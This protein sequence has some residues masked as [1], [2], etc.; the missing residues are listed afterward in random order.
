MAYHGLSFLTSRGRRNLKN[1]ENGMTTNCARR[2]FTLIELL[3]VLTIIGLMAAL[4][5]PL[6]A[7]ARERALII[8]CASNLHQ[9]GLAVQMYQQ[10]ADGI[11]PPAGPMLTTASPD[12]SVSRMDYLRPYDSDHKTYHCP[13]DSTPL[14]ENQLVFFYNYQGGQYL[15]PDPMDGRDPSEPP[16]FVLNPASVLMYCEKHLHPE[17]T[18][19]GAV[20][21]YLVLRADGSVSSVPFQNATWWHYNHGQWQKNV[22]DNYNMYRVFPQEPWP[23]QYQKS[24][25]YP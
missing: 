16:P 25:S 13:D 2:G 18:P 11:L 21:N 7:K 6:F 5:F 8:T 20:G 4:L 3:V 12:D 10:D 1:E 17:N 15:R 23:P 22:L 14:P 24:L 9:L 19:P